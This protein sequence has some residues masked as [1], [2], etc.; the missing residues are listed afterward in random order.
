MKDESEMQ[1]IKILWTGGFDSTCRMLQLSKLH[2]RVQPIY[3]IDGSN[4]K[5]IN[6][7]LHAISEIT[8]DIDAHPET[9]F[10]LLPLI[11]I[12]MDEIGEDEEIS[13][14][15]RN[16]R[17]NIP[18]GTQYEWLARFAKSNPNLELCFEKDESASLYHY[19]RSYEVM[20]RIE[21]GEVEY[22]MIDEAKTDSDIF[23]I[24]GNFRFPL[25][26][27]QTTKLE[28]IV[29][30]ERLGYE[31]TMHKTWF[32]HTPVNNEPCGVCNP[33]KITIKE[34]LTHRFSG[35]AMKR[36]RAEIKYENKFWYKICKKIRYRIAGY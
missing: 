10:D 19:L 13:T 24:L 8:K 34:G 36:Y 31:S 6:N 12:K 2:V 1:L 18:L 17:R 25:P 16:I 20:K 5:S 9:R 3:I 30:Y 28:M 35:E 26:L 15:H 32:C 22:C 11:K 27:L 14:A 7:E 23:T 29:E 33:C 21:E 4:R